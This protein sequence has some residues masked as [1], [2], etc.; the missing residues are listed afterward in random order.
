M[1]INRMLTDMNLPYL[2]CLRVKRA[3]NPAGTWKKSEVTSAHRNTPY[4]IS[5]RESKGRVDVTSFPRALTTKARSLYSVISILKGFR[6]S[7]GSSVES[8]NT[9]DFGGITKLWPP[10]FCAESLGGTQPRPFTLV[11]SMAAFKLQEQGWNSDRDH[12]TCKA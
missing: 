6:C 4:H 2:W 7:G 9:D 1:P 11:S 8:P 3:S 10:C 5:A 12:R